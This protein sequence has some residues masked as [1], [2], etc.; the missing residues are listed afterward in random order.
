MAVDTIPHRALQNAQ[1]IPHQPAYFVKE[2]GGWQPTSWGTYGGEITGAAKSLIALGVEQGNAIGILGFNRPEW[3]TMDVAAMAVGAVPAGIYTTNS[4]V[5]CQYIIEHSEAPVVLLEDESQWEKINVVRGELPN[6]R[7]VVMMKGSAEIDDPLVMSWGEFIAA[8][9]DIADSAL[10]ERLDG[11]EIG[12]LATLI[13]TSGTTGPPKGVMLSHDNLVWTASQALGTFDIGRGDK[14]LSYL[15][16]SHIAEQVFSIHAATLAGYAVY[17]AESI[18]ALA[19]NLQEVQPTLFFAVPRVWERFYA[20]VQAKMGEATGVKAKIASWATGVGRQVNELRNR[21]KEPSGALALQYKLADR[22]V[23]HKVKPALGL[24]EC[25]AAISGAAPVSKEI[26]EFF[27]GL[28]IPIYEVY[29]QSEDT[30]PTSTNVPGR[31]KY[32]SVGPAYPG[33]EIKIGDD[34]EVLVKGRNVFLGY[35]KSEEATAETLSDGWLHSGDLGQFDDDG[36]LYIT[37]RKKD[38]LVTSGGK[39]VAPIPIEGELKHHSLVSEAVLIGDRRKYLTA[40]VT[41]DEEAAEQFMQDRKLTG[42]SYDNNEI[43]DIIQVAV[44]EL[45]NRLARAEQ[46]KKFAILPRQ[47][48]IEGGELTPTLKVKRQRV[49]E[50]FADEI[51]ALYAE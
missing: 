18:E 40:V 41:L 32:G 20:G 24:A 38:I 8:G 44:D 43:R 13:Y 23:F 1:R 50:H 31:T 35:F 33:V 45:N 36:F 26:L 2:H 25:R 16:L 11:L 51:A 28:D 3:V 17:Y 49:M 47:L 9:A 5:E 30:G 12:G 46:V 10:D 21:G 27:S 34:G 22:L 14:A 48:S 19:E 42:S 29:G 39:N 4:P 37:G 6:L 15:P 7:H